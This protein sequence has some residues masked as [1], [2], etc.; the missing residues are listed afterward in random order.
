MICDGDGG[1]CVC[2]FTQLKQ[3][4][5]LKQIQALDYYMRLDMDSCMYGEPGDIFSRMKKENLSYVWHRM[6]RDPAYFLTGMRQVLQFLNSSYFFLVLNE[7][8]TNFL[9]VVHRSRSYHSR[10]LRP[11]TT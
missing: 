5:Q 1:G 9:F 8:E 11:V 4:F 10:A 2:K 3:V 6:S 7:K